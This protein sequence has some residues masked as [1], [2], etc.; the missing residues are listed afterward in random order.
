MRR[1]VNGHNSSEVRRMNF[2]WVSV[3]ALLIVLTHLVRAVDAGKSNTLLRQID[4]GFSAVFEKVAPVV[5]VIESDKT[6][7]RA[8]HADDLGLFFREEGGGTFK[9]PPVESRSEGSGFIIR[10]DGYI[11]TNYHVIRDAA[12]I[13]VRLRDGRLLPA[14]IIGSDDKTDIAVLKVEATGLA[15]AEFGDSDTIRVGQLVC[16]IGVP[17]NLDYSF[18]CGWISAKGRAGLT[19]TV[20]ED[21]IQTDAFINPGNSGGPLFDVD[22]RVIGMNTLI[23]GV[24]R[25]LAFAIPSNLLQAVTDQLIV[26]GKV[27]RPWIGIRMEEIERSGIPRDQLAG[28]QNGVV[29][30][31]I[32]PEGSACKSD[33]RVTD[34]ITAIDAVEIKR[35]SDLQREILKKKIGTTVQL[36][37]WRGG[38]TLEIPITT[39]ELPGTPQT[40]ANAAPSPTPP[41][42]D[43]FGLV[44]KE[45]PKE[46]AKALELLAGGCLVTEVAE[47]SPAAAAELKAGDILTEI[48]RQPVPTVD[49]ARKL[50]ASASPENG[51]LL[52]LNRNGQKTYAILRKTGE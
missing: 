33:L 18:T 37:V 30:R 41:S 39:S 19:N 50:L 15:P 24:G 8:D 47:N 42:A 14:K 40:A 29:V 7:D 23:N 11:V 12:K 31:T 16:A 25:G 28:I 36:R 20:Y 35:P 6:T 49:I 48:D 44:L 21:Y 3:F 52:F 43:A 27:S 22:G 51:A 5:V 1:V 38:K 13:E 4:E 2:R 32:F 34:V 26:A 45:L 46:K 10:A 17:F 9:L